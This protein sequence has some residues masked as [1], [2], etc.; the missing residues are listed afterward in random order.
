M[1]H[2]VESSLG[3]DLVTRYALWVDSSVVE[4]YLWVVKVRGSIPRSPHDFF[5]IPAISLSGNA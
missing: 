5:F 1:M 4:C 3:E 2:D